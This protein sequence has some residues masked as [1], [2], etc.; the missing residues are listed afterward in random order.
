MRDNVTQRV[1]FGWCL[2]ESGQALMLT[3][4]ALPVIVGLMGLVVDVAN[5]YFNQGRLQT[6]VDAA[7]LAGSKCLPDQ[8]NCNA[9]ATAENYA[10][11]N[12]IVATDNI[13]G[14]SVEGG[15]LSLAV[16]R[17]VP[18]YFARL[19]GLASATVAVSAAAQAGPAGSV[20]NALPL[21]LQAC[22]PSIPVC[23]T[24]YYTGESLTFAA[25]KNDGSGSWVSGSGDWSAVAIPYPTNT[26]SVCAPPASACLSSNPGFANIQTLIGEVN[27]LI[28]AGMSLDP[29]GSATSHSAD[30]PRAVAVPL[31]DWSL[32][33]AGCNG[34]CQL[35]VYGFAEIWLTGAANNGSNSSYITGQFTYQSVNGAMDISGTAH[36]VGTYAVKLIQ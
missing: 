4:F 14:P 10:A 31:V 29:G 1:L 9:L 33:G 15:R 24:P 26:V 32:G 13:I 7:V 8:A 3:T 6:A 27:N 21:G 36:D 17:V 30:D 23:T 34:S 35:N 12:G 20:N 11:G 19:L 18:L 2:R 28:A 16:K 5:V 22:G 25:K